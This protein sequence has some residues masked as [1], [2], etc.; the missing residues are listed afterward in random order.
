MRK[1]SVILYLVILLLVVLSGCSGKKG[2]ETPMEEASAKPSAAPTV[3]AAPSPDVTPSPVPSVT[4]SP[5]PTV[6]AS[7]DP[8]QNQLEQMSMNEKIGQ[9]VLAG[10][11]GTAN[12]EEAKN[13]IETYHIGG[14]ILYKDNIAGTKQLVSLLNSLKATN[15]NNQV[16]LWLSVDEEGGKVSRLPN[17]LSKFPSNKIIGEANNEKFSF[18]VG[19]TIG[20]QLKSY[21]FNVDFAPVMDVNS[22]PNNPVI[23]DRSFGADADVVSRLGI[24]TMKG[25]ES[26]HIL[27]VIKHFPGH[28]DT[29][30]DSHI[31]LPVIQHDIDRLRKLELV[32][33]VKAIKSGADA[34]MIA[35][36]LLPKLDV[37]N[38]AS[39]SKTIITKLLRQE[40][41][42]QG[43]VISD[44]MT[45]GAITENYKL[46]EAAVKAVLA[47]TDVVLVAHDYD[48]EV[49][50][51]NALRQAVK[52]KR[53]PV[54][55]ID[56][57]V[58]RILKLKLKYA[59]SDKQGKEPDIAKL[60]SEVN[61][62]V[63]TY[64][65]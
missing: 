55:T 34:V 63:K 59:I 3:T 58:A 47:G 24:Q 15:A 1:R 28:G 33:F 50:V 25:L 23:G 9:M 44:D 45:M 17:E 57:S 2:A 7:S 43:L 62:L 42:F 60:N 13:L 4:P 56:N 64:L 54:E 49:G 37:D 29:S 21:G 30:M 11:E 19:S 14:I 26:Q 12:S 8:V 52:D 51:V 6:S 10:I 38:P 39:F 20:T 61:K 40:L 18:A 36:I 31:G 65:P 32:P 41:G 16:P 53:I 27:P 22:N 35:H 46:G 5:V 48:K